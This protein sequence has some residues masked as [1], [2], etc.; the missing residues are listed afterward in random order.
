MSGTARRYRALRR[1]V[2]SA[3]ISD[4]ATDREKE[5][6]VRRRLVA[7]TGR[8][9]CGARLRLPEHFEPGTATVVAVEHAPDCPATEQP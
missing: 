6:A 7:T 9:P 3:P 5:G 2:L 8:C 1:V 4:D